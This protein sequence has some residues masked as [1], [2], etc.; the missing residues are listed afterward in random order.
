MDRDLRRLDRGIGSNIRSSILT[1]YSGDLA[2]IYRAAVCITAGRGELRAIRTRERWVSTSIGPP[3]LS[4]INRCVS[5]TVRRQ[6]DSSVVS[7]V[8]FPPV[9]VA[10]NKGC[11]T[12]AQC[13]REALWCKKIVLEKCRVRVN[14]YVFEAFL[15]RFHGDCLVRSIS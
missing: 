3:A 9:T 13:H 15:I 8:V 11:A 14:R 5:R 12:A 2:D 6:L 7:V 1:S 10:I 4:K